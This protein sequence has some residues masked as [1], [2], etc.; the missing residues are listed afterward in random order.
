MCLKKYEIT[1]SKKLQLDSYYASK[2]SMRKF[3]DTLYFLTVDHL[4]RAHS[5]KHKTSHPYLREIR[6]RKV[7]PY[8]YSE[9]IYVYDP[10]GLDMSDITYE[11]DV[12][13]KK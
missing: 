13:S 12:K 2:G 4:T 11:S 3:L 1:V 9:K 10:N 6:D 7:V 8:T 5:C